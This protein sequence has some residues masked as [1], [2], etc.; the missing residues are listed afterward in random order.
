VRVLAI[1]HRSTILREAVSYRGA[2]LAKSAHLTLTDALE[3][4]RLQEFMA[5]Y[6]GVKAEP[7][8]FDRLVKPTARTQ[9]RR[10]VPRTSR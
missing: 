7:A 1:E 10:K 4:N 6:K 8:S 9:R 5:Q 2:H 3:Q